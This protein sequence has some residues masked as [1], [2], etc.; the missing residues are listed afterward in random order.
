V[1]I[2]NQRLANVEP[3]RQTILNYNG[4]KEGIS[5]NHTACA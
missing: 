1:K 4:Y 2:G 3:R 5:S